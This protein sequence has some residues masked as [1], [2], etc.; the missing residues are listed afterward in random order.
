MSNEELIKMVGKFKDEILS[1]RVN[2]IFMKRTAAQ[3]RA[4]KGALSLANFECFYQNYRAGN[5]DAV[6][7]SWE[8]PSKLLRILDELTDQVS[9]EV[10]SSF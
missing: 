4:I 5:K 9:R 10:K 6:E 3:V 7:H 1:L 2:E 8:L